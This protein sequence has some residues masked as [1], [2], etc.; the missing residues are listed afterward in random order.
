MALASA[1]GN[2]SHAPIH[3]LCDKLFRMAR[4]WF[5][6]WAIPAIALA[7]LP[8]PAQIAGIFKTFQGSDTPGCAVGVETSGQD[9]WTAAYGMADL[10]HGV[11]N[12]PTTVFEAGGW[13]RGARENS[14]A[15]V[16]EVISRQ[17]G[18]DTVAK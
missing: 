7:Q 4:T 10:E 1:G 13:P 15:R 16:L 11:Q 5:L 12:T 2:P 17:Q 9:A 14:N 6:L 18:A 3:T 8:G